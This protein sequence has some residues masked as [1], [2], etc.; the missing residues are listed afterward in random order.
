MAVKVRFETIIDLLE[1]EQWTACSDQAAQ[2]LS[3]DDWSKEQ[4]A[5]LNFA[6]CRSLRRIARYGAA[7]EPGQLAVYLAEDVKDYDLFG[8]ALME[9]AAVQARLPGLEWQAVQ[10]QRRY[11][12]YY[13]QYKDTGRKLYSTA[14]YN[15]AVCLRAAGD[16]EEALQQFLQAFEAAKA[17]GNTDLSD[18][19]RRNA[20]WQALE[21]N[22][23]ELAEELIQQG[24]DYTGRHTHNMRAKASHM[25]DEAQLAYLKK[26]YSEATSL[27]I[28]AAVM[29]KA[30]PELF[31]DALDVL[32]RIG[33]STGDIEGALAFAI[34]AKEQ[35]EAHERYD[36]M[37]QLRAS[38]RE[39]AIRHPEAVER[40]MKDLAQ[41]ER[42]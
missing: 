26:K 12:D 22:Q 16:H 41:L 23:L 10:T 15:L 3:Q 18:Q 9:L 31:S 19:C 4:K 7:L 38:V 8:R 20:A 30:I 37:N 1:R 33:K 24:R 21:L 27:A 2:A 11:F 25:I 34:L 13:N 6:L 5:I 36:L 32:H 42:P 29:A 28:E 35:A 17:R 39:M 40:F 14:M